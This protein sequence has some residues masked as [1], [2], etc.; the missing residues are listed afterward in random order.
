MLYAKVHVSTT[1]EVLD[2]TGLLAWR[3][4]AGPVAL[5]LVASIAV[6]RPLT[7][8]QRRRLPKALKEKLA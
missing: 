5:S 7:A 3:R 1:V 4:N 8:S 2:H 6:R